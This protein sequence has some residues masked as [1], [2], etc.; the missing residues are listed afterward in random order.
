MILWGRQASR[1]APLSTKGYIEKHAM[2]KIADIMVTDAGTLQPFWSFSLKRND[3]EILAW[4]VIFRPSLNW[5]GRHEVEPGVFFNDPPFN[6]LINR[7]LY[8]VS[9]EA[10][11][12]PHAGELVAV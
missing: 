7:L 4:P 8:G 3:L 12:Y 1:F 5:P 10:G 6:G 11:I 9:E 2:R